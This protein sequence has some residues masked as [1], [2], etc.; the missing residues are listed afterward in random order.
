MHFHL[1]NRK[2]G[3]MMSLVGDFDNIKM[4]RIQEMEET[5]GLEQIWFYRNGQLHCKVTANPVTPSPLD[6]LKKKTKKN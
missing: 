5:G 2:S 6:V 1:R 3:L 4:M